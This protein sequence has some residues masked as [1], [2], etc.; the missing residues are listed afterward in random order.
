MPAAFGGGF[1]VSDG[2]MLD[3]DLVE[4]CFE[5]AAQCAHL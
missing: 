4:R 3:V 1:A 2:T 5:G